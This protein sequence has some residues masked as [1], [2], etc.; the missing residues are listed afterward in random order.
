MATKRNSSKTTRRLVAQP[1]AEA[2]GEHEHPEGEAEGNGG[3]ETQ[4]KLI[5]KPDPNFALEQNGIKVKKQVTVPVL[6][7]PPGS[8]IL[9]QIITPIAQSAISDGKMGPARVVE[10]QAINGSVRLLIVGEVLHSALTRAY[11]KNS[12]VGRWF[13]IQKLP[14]REDKR[15]ADYA[16]AEIED[17]HG[18][19]HQS[20]SAR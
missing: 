3:N 20:P 17:P 14:A 18:M 9:C 5:V 15:Y 16:V 13:S 19:V 6:P 1:D 4:G 7:F 2:Q 12:Y 8:S 11:E 10:I